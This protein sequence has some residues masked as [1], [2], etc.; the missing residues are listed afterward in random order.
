M[1]VNGEEKK[2]I[3]KEYWPGPVS[4]ILP[5]KE[6]KLEYLHRG[7]GGIA[8]RMP[9]KKEVVAFLK[10]TGPIVAPSANPEGMSPAY[11]VESAREYFGDKVDFYINGGQLGSFPSRL[12]RLKDGKAE[13]IR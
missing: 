9:A 8:F 3:K 7:S 12:I 11:S 13:D 1:T 6:G 2:L 10:K 4:I 5:C